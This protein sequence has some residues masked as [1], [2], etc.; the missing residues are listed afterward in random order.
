MGLYKYL[1]RILDEFLIKEHGELSRWARLLVNQAKVSLYVGREILTENYLQ[2]AAALAFTTLLSLIPLFTVSF[3]LVRAFGGLPPED[4]ESRVREALSGFF[5]ARPA[6]ELRVERE[7]ATVLELGALPENAPDREPAPEGEQSEEATEASLGDAGQGERSEDR[8]AIRIEEIANKIAEIAR[9]ASSG[10]LN[11][12]GIAVLIVVSVLLFNTIETAFNE[13]W[14][15]ER[16]RSFVV[17]FPAFCTILLLGPLLVGLSIYL[18]AK[19]DPMRNY[20]D[21]VRTLIGPFNQVLLFLPPLLITWFAFFLIYVLMPNTRVRWRSALTGALVA[22]TIW[23]VAKWGFGLY[24][25]RVVMYS[26]VYGSLAGVPIFLMWI[27]ISWVIVLFG[28]AIAYSKQNVEVIS[29]RRRHASR[30]RPVSELLALLV[31]LLVGRHFRRGDGPTSVSVLS[32]EADVSE[33]DVQRVADR[34]SAAGVLIPVGAGEETYN[35]GRSLDTITA[36]HILDV[37]RDSNARAFAGVDDA[38]GKRLDLLLDQV[39]EQQVEV[40]DKISVSD[41]IVQIEEKRSGGR[42]DE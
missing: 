2:K 41:L 32:T 28:A 10:A 13:I 39:R 38:V 8:V 31:A 22:G 18:T 36:Q 6:A 17:K 5:L 3:A 20:I 15:V 12:V 30:G 4:V 33:E 40:L 29:A 19:L 37:I 27:F 35:P 23:E 9:T 24:V 7:G 25:S 14:H 42:D 21:Q 16:R 34:L 26:R 1:A 11:V